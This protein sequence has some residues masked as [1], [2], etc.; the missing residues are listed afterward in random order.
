MYLILNNAVLITLAICSAC[1]ILAPFLA[2]ILVARVLH[3]RPNLRVTRSGLSVAAGVLATIGFVLGT[4]VMT[5]LFAKD[6]LFLLPF[7]ILFGQLYVIGEMRRIRWQWSLVR[8]LVA[9]KALDMVPT[10]EP[11]SDDENPVK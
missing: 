7:W 1:L 6:F 5:R 4:L 3:H 8:D 11:V 9:E 2:T 10:I